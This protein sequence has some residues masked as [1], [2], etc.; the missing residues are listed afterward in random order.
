LIGSLNKIWPWKQALDGVVKH[1]GEVDEE[2]VVTAFENT[3]PGGYSAIS[4]FEKLEM[5]LNIGDKDP[6]TM[7]AILAMTGG[8]AIIFILERIAAKKPAEKPAE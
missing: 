4:E 8:L 6:Q 1:A 2:I 5:G 7:Y 3:L